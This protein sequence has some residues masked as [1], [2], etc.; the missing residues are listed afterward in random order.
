MDKILSSDGLAIWSSVCRQLGVE[1]SRENSVHD[2]NVPPKEG[3]LLSLWPFDIMVGYIHSIYIDY[4][5]I[6][7]LFSHSIMHQYITSDS[8]V[9][10]RNIVSI[11]PIGFES[12]NMQTGDTTSSFRCQ[13]VS[14]RDRFCLYQEICT[15]RSNWLSI[16]SVNML[17][18][19]SWQRHDD[20]LST[21]SRDSSWFM[22][23]QSRKCV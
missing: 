9:S 1:R 13:C 14:G 7:S 22:I 10:L 5:I 17:T 6:S 12:H 16:W 15:V 11:L 3:H 8:L 4:Y 19:K 2:K 23:L 18:D 20:L 21:V